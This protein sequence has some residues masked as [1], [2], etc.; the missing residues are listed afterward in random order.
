M[1]AGL[2]ADCTAPAEPG[3]VRCK[4]HLA[5]DYEHRK[6]Y[7]EKHKGTRCLVCARELLETDRER[8]HVKCQNCR[9]ETFSLNW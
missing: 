7:R 1:E 3:R 8:G 9:E 5:A 6:T 2:C 4:K